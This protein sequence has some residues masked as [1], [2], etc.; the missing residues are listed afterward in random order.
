MDN[1]R[2]FTS[3]R[4]NYRDLYH[5]I[6]VCSRLRSFD[7]ADVASLCAFTSSLL[8]IIVSEVTTIFAS[9]LCIHP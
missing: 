6:Y 3:I 5:G 4:F 9:F 7:M 8:H 1:P 2:I